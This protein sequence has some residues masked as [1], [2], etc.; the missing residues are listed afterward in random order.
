[1]PVYKVKGDYCIF[2]FSKEIESK[3]RAELSSKIL[4]QFGLP[5]YTEKKEIRKI[6]LFCYN[7]FVSKFKEIIHSETSIRTYQT[8]FEFHEQSIEIQTKYPNQDLSVEISNSY[9]SVYRRIL[10]LILEEVCNVNLVSSKSYGHEIIPRIAPIIEDLLFLGDGI[11]RI[12]ALIAEQYMVED[13]IEILFDQEN[14][15]VFKRKDY[16]DQLF[17]YFE[18]E[19]YEH[20]NHSIID[21]KGLNDFKDALKDCFNI[22]Y[23]KTSNILAN[24]HNELGDESTLF[25]WKELP[26]SL[27]KNTR[28]ELSV[29]EQLYK[30][31]T[32]SKDNKLDIEK[33]PQKPHSLNRFL[34]RPILIW[35]LDGDNLAICG[36][37][38]W[39]ESITEL[40]LNTIPWGKAPEEWTNNECF[41]QYVHKK[42]DEHEKWLLDATE[43][44]LKAKQVIYSRNLKSLKQKVSNN[45]RIDIEGLGEIDFVYIRPKEKKI[46]LVDCKYLKARYDMVNFR[47]DYSNFTK[48]N[49]SGYDNRMKKKVKWF[50]DNLN[51]AEE[52]FKIESTNDSLNLDG[53]NIEGIFVINSPTF[54]M[55]NSTYSIYTLKTFK[56]LIDGAFQNKEFRI[57]LEEE[58]C[59]KTFRVKYPYLRK[60][61]NK[62]YI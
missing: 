50:E 13:S 61:K 31:L 60:L 35:N 28:C 40:W 59:V 58:N 17:G 21:N 32:L 27:I 1:M 30:G 47:V 56:E 2:K 55:Y 25:P 6:L 43:N 34:Y 3:F 18:R 4:N 33:V 26:H 22:D 53:Y 44:I 14:K 8:V 52:H 23:N 29:C 39:E 16:Y 19:Y 37:Y 48:K 9:F 46:Y 38:S 11:Y 51:K 57:V 42:E 45:I 15:Y 36:K 62:E 10:K 5:P 54:Y 49:G 24:I 20:L 7:Y 12:T 41:K